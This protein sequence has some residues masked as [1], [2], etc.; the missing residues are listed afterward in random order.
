[1]FKN[2]KSFLLRLLSYESSP[3]KL[4]L[5][6][7]SALYVSFSPFMGLHTLMLIGAGWF[8]ETSIPLVVMLGYV[9]NN[10]FTVVPIVMSGYLCGYWIL[11]TI[12]GISV[13]AAN[14]D[15]MDALNVYLK[16]KLGL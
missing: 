4:A 8:F 9:I 11:H 15:W 2:I 5:A 13:L 1:M 3:H 14:P 10:P 16:V 6:C 7:A 12:M